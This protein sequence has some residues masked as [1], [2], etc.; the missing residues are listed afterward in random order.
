[1]S[2]TV[3]HCDGA[4]CPTYPADC[5]ARQPGRYLLAVH[6]LTTDRDHRASTAEVSDALGVE[7]PST[8]EMLG[9]LE[10]RGLVDHENYRG[11]TLTDRG[12]TVAEEL[13]W[14][15]RSVRAF[16]VSRIDLLLEWE[17]AYRIGYV[18]PRD[19]VERLGVLA[20]TRPNR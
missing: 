10:N 15:Q 8:T 14:R 9:K 2:A 13:R 16:F 12:E 6:R 5:I 1:M 4:C 3:G 19:A 20:E 18:L 17:T 11:T 7:A